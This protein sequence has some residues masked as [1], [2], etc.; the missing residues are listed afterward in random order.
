[1]WFALCG[2]QY[3]DNRGSKIMANVGDS[4]SFCKDN[5]VPLTV[6]HKPISS[7]KKKKV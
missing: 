7:E 4:N 2:I 5:A 3:V 6:D 1:M